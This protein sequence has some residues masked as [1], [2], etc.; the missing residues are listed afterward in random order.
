MVKGLGSLIH[1]EAE[2]LN[3][4]AAFWEDKTSSCTG[5]GTASQ[6]LGL[7]GSWCHCCLSSFL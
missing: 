2:D 1:E 7:T 4:S 5:A 6:L 3:S